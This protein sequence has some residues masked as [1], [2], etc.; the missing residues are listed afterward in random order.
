MSLLVLGKFKT[1]Q[2][3]P[4]AIGVVRTVLGWI[5]VFMMGRA[6]DAGQ[7][8]TTVLWF[9]VFVFAVALDALDGWVARR[10]QVAS[11]LGSYVDIL[12]DRL[13]EYPAWLLLA[14]AAPRL[15]PLVVVIVVRNLLVDFVKFE[16]TRKGVT[17]EAGVPKMNRIGEFLVNHPF[18]KTMHNVLKLVA[19]F[20]GFGYACFVTTWLLAAAMGALTLHVLFCSARGLCSLVELRTIWRSKQGTRSTS[21]LW[22]YAFQVTIGIVAV[23]MLFV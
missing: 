2:M 7:V 1:Y 9:G 10:L 22:R 5:A 20:A 21:D 14:S 4:S 13:T 19:L 8:N 6:L 18:C 11:S 16:A 15:G 12:A 23:L 3:L 17:M